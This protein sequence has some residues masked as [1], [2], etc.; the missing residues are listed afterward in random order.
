MSK[1]LPRR[2]AGLIQFFGTFFDTILGT[3]TFECGGCWEVR[4]C[5]GLQD[6]G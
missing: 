1:I 3:F 2:F 4:I 6:E 5:L